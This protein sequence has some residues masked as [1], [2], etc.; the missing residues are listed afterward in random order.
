LWVAEDRTPGSQQPDALSTAESLGSLLEAQGRLAETEPL[1][2][3]GAGAREHARTR[4]NLSSLLG[5]LAGQVKAREAREL[6]AQHGG[7][8]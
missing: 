3:E 2:R 1:Y 6:R 7:A 4:K 5:V 8:K